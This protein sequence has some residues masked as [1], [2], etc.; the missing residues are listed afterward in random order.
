MEVIS[1]QIWSAAASEVRRR[2]GWI[3]AT[4]TASQAPIQ[5]A[6]VAALCRRTP[7]KRSERHARRKLKRARATRAK[8]AACCRNGLAETRRAQKTRAG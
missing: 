7:Q 6:V 5:S 3:V 4:S 8:H 1:K 2:L